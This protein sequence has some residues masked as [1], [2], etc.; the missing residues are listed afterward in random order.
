MITAFLSFLSFWGAILAAGSFLPAIA[1]TIF[2][3][4]SK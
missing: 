1:N 4:F 2:G 3:W